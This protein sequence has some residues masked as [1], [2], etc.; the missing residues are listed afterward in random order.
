MIT[1]KEI[2]L[3][4]TETKYALDSQLHE[5]NDCVRI[6]YQWLDAQNKTKSI[7]RKGHALK[8]LIEAWAGRYVSNSDVCVAAQLHPEIHGSYPRFNIS[9]RLTEPSL[10]RLKDIPEAMTHHYRDNHKSS[11][12]KNHE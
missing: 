2:E 4:K 7:G 10:D 5:H 1:D 8:H 11:N 9:A 12:Y 3:A 6:A